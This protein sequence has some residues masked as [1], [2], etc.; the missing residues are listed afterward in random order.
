VSTQLIRPIY[1]N[2]NLP[3]VAKKNNNNFSMDWLRFGL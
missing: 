1:V 3:I 2:N